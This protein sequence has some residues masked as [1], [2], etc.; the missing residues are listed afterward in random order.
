MHDVQSIA[1]SRWLRV[2]VEVPWLWAPGPAFSP[3]FCNKF[4]CPFSLSLSLK[5]PLGLHLTAKWY[6]DGEKEVSNVLASHQF[7][8]PDMA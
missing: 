1:R 8:I 3:S 7:N 4:E 5:L 2:G 6:Y